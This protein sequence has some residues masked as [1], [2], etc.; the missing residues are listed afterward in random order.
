MAARAN[1]LLGEAL[2]GLA[3]AGQAQ[4]AYL[5][6]L[7]VQAAVLFL[8]WPKRGLFRVLER[9]DAVPFLRQTMGATN[10]A[11]AEP[12]TLR[13]LYATSIERNAI[14]GNSFV[15]NRTQVKYVGTRD[16][17]WSA[18][19]RG[20]YWSDNPAFDLDGDGVADRPF[21]PNGLVDQILWREPLAKLLLNSPAVQVLRWAQ[22]EFPTLHPG[23]VRDSAPL[24]DPP[25]I[26]P[27][28]EG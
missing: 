22:S 3:G 8:W 6:C 23:G 7:L 28:G 24:M 9:E 19:G 20:N 1:P 25:A 21:R 17:E 12:G 26:S 14:H 11:E 2:R 10:P 13:A 5:G 27:A 16:V 15:A 4:H 18:G